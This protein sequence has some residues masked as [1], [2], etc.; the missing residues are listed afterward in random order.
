VTVPPGDALPTPPLA[1]A[2]RERVVEVLT[3]HFAA[4]RITAEDLEA[5][6]ERVYRATTR[7]ELEG[8]IADLPAALPAQSAPRAVE[9]A[10]QRIAA[11]LSGQE[12]RLSGVVPSGLEV[13]SRL[14]YVELDLTGATFAPG[15]TEIHVRAFLGY[16]QIRFPAGVRVESRG[17]AFAGFFS[18]KGAAEPGADAGLP[19]VRVTGRAGFGFAE[20]F[21]SGD[22]QA[23][24]AGD[25]GR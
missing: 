22:R 16:V 10:P 2:A 15:V 4:D 21:V 24:P 25:A 12:Q 13:R 19:V 14:G 17:R 3:R 11:F 9:P 7:A 23:L 20:C 8:L 6:L 18:L 5:R 1:P